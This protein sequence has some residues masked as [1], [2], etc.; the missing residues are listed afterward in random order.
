MMRKES[1][2]IRIARPQDA[3]ALLAIYAPYVEKTAVTF[4]YEVPAVGEFEERIRCVLQKYPWLIAEQNGA[5]VG[6]A[7]ASPFH[8]RP[9][10]GWAVETS[11]YVKE[12]A[13]KS[14]VGRALY[15]ALEGML[16]RQNILNLNACIAYPETE[17]CYLTKNS[18]HFHAHMGYRLV[19]EFHQCGYKFGRWYNMV[20]MEK[21]IG[22]HVSDPAAVRTFGEIV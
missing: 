13:A 2:N 18:V 12:G 7:Y 5:A 3:V 20:W 19:G 11:V 6:Y 22:A 4:E 14:G 21:L 9:A 17:D 8:A 16:S 10:Y 15:E 1:V